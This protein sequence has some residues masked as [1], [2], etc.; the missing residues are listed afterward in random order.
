MAWVIFYACNGERGTRPV[1]FRQSLIL[2]SAL[3]VGWATVM[4][5]ALSSLYGLDGGRSTRVVIF[6]VIQYTALL[7]VVLGGSGGPGV[8]GWPFYYI[9]VALLWAVYRNFTYMGGLSP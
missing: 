8:R 3:L 7:V 6:T 2:T 1:P 5:I 4:Y 9:G